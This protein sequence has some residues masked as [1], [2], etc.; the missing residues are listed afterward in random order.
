M[1]NYEAFVTKS[2]KLTGL[3]STGSAHSPVTV[4]GFYKRQRILSIAERLSASQAGLFSVD[5]IN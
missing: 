4:F 5:L 1:L 2:N 3:N